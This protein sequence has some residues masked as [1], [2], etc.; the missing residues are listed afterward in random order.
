MDC[1]ANVTS[2][3]VTNCFAIE[4]TRPPRAGLT[5]K[6]TWSPFVNMSRTRFVECGNSPIEDADLR[7]VVITSLS[8]WKRTNGMA[9]LPWAVTVTL[10]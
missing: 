7:A 3:E 1:P 10:N 4:P 8:L 2:L 5:F 9:E 6:I